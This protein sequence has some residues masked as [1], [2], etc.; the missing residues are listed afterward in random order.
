VALPPPPLYAP[1]R[2][3]PDV[4]PVVVGIT[5]PVLVVA[6]AGAAIFFVVSRNMVRSRVEGF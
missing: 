4:T 1:A 5:V 3:S 6:A 2:P